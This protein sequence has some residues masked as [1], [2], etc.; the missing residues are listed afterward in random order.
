MEY[1]SPTSRP[2]KPFSTKFQQQTLWH[3]SPQH[4]TQSVVVCLFLVAVTFIP[5]GAAIIVASDTVFEK[6]YRYDHINKCTATKHSSQL[7]VTLGGATYSQGCITRVPLTLTKSLAAPVQIYYRLVGMYQNYRPYAKSKSDDQM[8]GIRMARGDSNAD[9]CT[10][11]LGPDQRGAN[12]TITVGTQAFTPG[13]LV[14]HPCGTVPWSMFND[15]ISLYSVASAATVTPTGPLPVGATAKCIGKAFT[16]N[17]TAL[18]PTLPC[19]KKGIAL[20]A[21]AT[22]RFKPVP[23]GSPE[24]WTGQGEPTSSDPYQ[25]A[26]Y[27]FGEAGQQVP[28]TD[29]EDFMVWMRT[30]GVADFWKPYRVLTQ[31]LVAGDY[32]LEIEEFWDSTSFGGE[33]HVVIATTSW[34]GG[35]NY[36][37]GAI[38]IVLGSI[39][40]VFGAGFLVHF[41]V[42]DKR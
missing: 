28:R 13:S 19:A 1:H 37:L 9:L 17:G 30:A 36:V 6:F 34:I 41:L 26:G 10:P 40:F 16:A 42:S 18:L 35:K 5:L 32:A 3:F 12:V 15:T 20:A 25:R 39:A 22:A 7:N 27:Y 24:L 23:S 2:E 33:K 21:D 11:F 8:S 29:D 31:D 14:Y 38:Y 4:S